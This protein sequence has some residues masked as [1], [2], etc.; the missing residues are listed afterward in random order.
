M[1]SSGGGHLILVLYLCCC[2]GLND[3]LKKVGTEKDT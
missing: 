1:S 2:E 3:F